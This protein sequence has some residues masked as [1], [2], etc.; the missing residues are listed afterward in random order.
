M[1]KPQGG[2]NR[3]RFIYNPRY[4]S[5][6]LRVFE[7]GKGG[8]KIIINEGSFYFE[9][10]RWREIDLGEKG[11]INRPMVFPLEPETDT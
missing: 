1:D 2:L 8:C 11:E 6:C 4:F 9:K 10:K 5:E 3:F 7:N